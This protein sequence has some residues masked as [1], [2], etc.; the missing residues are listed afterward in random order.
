MKKGFKWLVLSSVLIFYAFLYIATTKRP[1]GLP[2]AC[3]EIC[4]K[5]KRIDTLVRRVYTQTSVYSCRSDMVCLLV[6]DSASIN[7]K[8]LADTTCMYLNNEG[9]QNYTVSVIGYPSQDTLLK[10][11]CP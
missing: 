9:L 5:V 8:N 2:P 7:S 11:K 6:A 4:D 3:D 10:Q 1:Y